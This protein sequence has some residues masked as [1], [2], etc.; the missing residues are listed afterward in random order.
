MA[1]KSC[2]L[3]HN[4]LYWTFLSGINYI[5]VNL[6]AGEIIE[7]ILAKNACSSWFSTKFLRWMEECINILRFVFEWDG[8]CFQFRVF[9]CWWA[10]LRRIWSGCRGLC[11]YYTFNIPSQVGINLKRGKGIPMGW[12]SS[13]SS[14]DW[15]I[16]RDFFEAEAGKNN[17]KW[18]HKDGN[19]HT[20]FGTVW[21]SKSSSSTSWMDSDCLRLVDVDWEIL[22]SVVFFEVDVE[23]E[24]RRVASVKK[25]SRAIWWAF[26]PGLLVFATSAIFTDAFDWRLSCSGTHADI[27]EGNEVNAVF[28]R[29]YLKLK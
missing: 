1:T 12:T 19:Q 5:S 17:Y 4:G 24:V 18:P 8:G 20:P 23:V 27:E 14:S 29:R 7:D 6:N 9:R 25:R 11:C 2:W 22:V 13:T 26:N 15:K 3:S 16:I 21:E 28:T 10:R